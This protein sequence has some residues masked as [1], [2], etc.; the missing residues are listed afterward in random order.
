MHTHLGAREGR[1]TRRFAAIAV[2]V[3]RRRAGGPA[4]VEP[5]RPVSEMAVDRDLIRESF[6]NQPVRTVAQGLAT[7]SGITLLYLPSYSPNRQDV[8]CPLR[9]YSMRCYDLRN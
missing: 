3:S 5:N 7:Q 8:I 9:R 2:N 4:G 1:R 6:K